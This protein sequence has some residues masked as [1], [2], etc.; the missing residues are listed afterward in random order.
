MG[1]IV[2][3]NEKL[4]RFEFRKLFQL[5]GA[6]LL[7]TACAPKIVQ[8]ILTPISTP[9]IPSTSTPN[10]PTNTPEP[11]HEPPTNTP[12]PTPSY[13]PRELERLQRIEKYGVA[14]KI[15]SLEFHGDNYNMY[16]GA[17]TMN[18]NTFEW[19]M[20]WFKN[21]EVW[22]LNQ[23]ELIGYLDGTM[24]MPAR[25]VILTTDSG[26]TSL[27]SLPRMIPVLQ[28][29]G[30]HF[31]SL[32]WTRNMLESETS[33][34]KYDSCWKTFEDALKSGVYSFGTHTES[35]GD[36]STFTLEKGLDDILQS[37]QEI[38]NRLG[39]NVK[40]LSW[41]FEACPVWGHELKNYGIEA[42]FGGNIRFIKE[43]TVYP[44]DPARYCLPRLLPPNAGSRV[45]GRPNGMT[46][47]EMMKTYT[48]GFD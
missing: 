42:A 34:C 10:P 23:D 2:S 40:V 35:H 39:I 6:S 43:N 44:E 13:T 38:E 17:Y 28:Y 36:F 24:N 48:N 47:Y 3:D 26:N 16:D 14:T 31:I 4:T 12:E 27:E 37:K 29:T 1:D 33:K 45:S 21:N 32:I 5:Y 9:Y 7:I 15:L 19:M 22:S 20:N 11:T 41:P 8:K 25:S 30:M 18:P 46:L